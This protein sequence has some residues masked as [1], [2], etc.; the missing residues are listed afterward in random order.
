MSEVL[1]IVD[2][3]IGPCPSCGATNDRFVLRVGHTLPKEGDCIFHRGCGVWHT[4]VADGLRP[5]T[6]EEVLEW[7]TRHGQ[8]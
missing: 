8:V 7:R 5:S 4:V 2:H 3:P 1:D 6:V